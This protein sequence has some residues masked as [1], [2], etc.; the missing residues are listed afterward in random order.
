MVWPVFESKF[1]VGSSAKTKPGRVTSARA[2]AT[3]CRCPP[4]SSLGRLAI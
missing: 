2:M 3:R 4:E 1:A